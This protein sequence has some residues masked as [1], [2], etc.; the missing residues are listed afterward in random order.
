M[1]HG[2]WTGKFDDDDDD[3]VDNYDDVDDDDDDE[4]TVVEYDESDGD[5]FENSD[6][7][8]RND[9]MKVMTVSW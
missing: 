4:D 1:R 7:F 2:G 6:R 8:C 3:N 9:M 5:K